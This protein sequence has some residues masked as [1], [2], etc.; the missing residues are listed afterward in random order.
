MTLPEL[1]ES[2]GLADD[3][4][5]AHPRDPSIAIGADPRRGV[6]YL[7]AVD[8]P[9]DATVLRRWTAQD[10]EIA[11]GMLNRARCIVESGVGDMQ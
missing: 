7:I 3:M 1:A 5:A 10:A 4:L 2:L 8:G 9:D 11:V 6:V